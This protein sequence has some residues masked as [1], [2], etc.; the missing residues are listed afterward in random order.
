MADTMHDGSSEKGRTGPKDNQAIEIIAGKVEEVPVSKHPVSTI[1]ET[2]VSW[3][4]FQRK[5]FNPWAWG[6]YVVLILLAI[7]VPYWAGRRLALHHTARVLRMLQPFTAQG[8]TFISWMVAMAM[9]AFLGLAI[10]VSKYW[11]F[12]V[13]FA[14]GLAFEQLIAG[15]CVLKLNFWYSTRVLYGDASA[16]PN[17]ANLG[18]LAAVLGVGVFAVVFVG[19]LV[20]IRRDS[21]L[22]VLTHSW[23]AFLL[24]FAIEA[25]AI[26]F[27]IFVGIPA[28]AAA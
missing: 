24:F 28:V 19:L 15:M 21:P 14:L 5:R 18:I 3:A 16:L 11:L 13:L 2:D 20:V 4:D 6:A 1:P 10:V 25:I 27:A 26:L 9:F 17:A 8:V 22:N 7:V 12:R 23:A